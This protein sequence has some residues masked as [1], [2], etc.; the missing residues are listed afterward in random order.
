VVHGPRDGVA[1]FTRNRAPCV[2]GWDFV[3][4]FGCGNV[5]A[6]VL[7]GRGSQ[8]SVRRWLGGAVKS[9]TS[10]VDRVRVAADDDDEA[11]NVSFRVSLSSS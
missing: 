1:L 10:E 4:S 5:I 8:R 7:L 2:F 11:T 3:L 6:R 9:R